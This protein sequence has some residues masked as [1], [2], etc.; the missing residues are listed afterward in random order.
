MR[1]HAV[2]SLVAVSAM[3]AEGGEEGILR[4]EG[5]L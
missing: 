1:S 5:M 3:V 4:T 2:R